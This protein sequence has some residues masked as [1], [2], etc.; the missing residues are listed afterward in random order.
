MWYISLAAWGEFYRRKLKLIAL[1]SI[2]EALVYA[3]E[4]AQI[5]LHTDEPDDFADTHFPCEVIFRRF[6]GGTEG[7]AIYNSLG[8]ADKM[9]IELVPK[10]ANIA[11]IT[12]DVMVSRE[13]FAASE[14]RL[15]EGARCIVGHAARTLVALD[16]CPAGLDAR[17]L[18]DFCF[19]KEHRH[20]ITAGCFY[21]QGTNQIAW[22]TYFEGPHGIVA[23]AFHLFPFA[24]KNDRHLSNFGGPTVDSDL[25][26]LFSR[27]EIYVACDPNEMAWA[28]I[29]GL[30]RCEMPQ[31][32]NPSSIDSIVE[33]ARRA[34]TPLQRWIF[35]HRV[36]VQ[37][38]GDDHLDEE[39][40]N[41]IL[42]I[43]G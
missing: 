16:D 10:G 37:G 30:E 29:S 14:K 15:A 39:P 4:P 8:Q 24:V 11:F 20:P 41:E 2:K 27:D 28:E 43:L 22:M 40:A 3:T 33:Y 34:A 21:G 7:V 31:L 12:S 26:E 1:P 36:I 23:R 18:L 13:F 25:F 32:S 35:S 17:K 9:A 19:L 6:Q 5:I 38:T 42:R